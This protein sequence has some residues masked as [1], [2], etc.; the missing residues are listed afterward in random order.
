MS[1]KTLLLWIH[2]L[3]TSRYPKPTNINYSTKSKRDLW[4]FNHLTWKK[5]KNY[6]LSTAAF[7]PYADNGLIWRVLPN[8]L[9][10]ISIFIRRGELVWS[11]NIVFGVYEVECQIFAFRINCWQCFPIVVFAKTN[12]K[13]KVLIMNLQILFL[14]FWNP[15]L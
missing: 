2:P 1:R 14:S 6:Y 13:I 9:N 8:I 15:R 4:F 5:I 10:F 7:F 11:N 12:G 3:P